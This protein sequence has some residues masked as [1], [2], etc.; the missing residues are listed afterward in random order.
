MKTPAKSPLGLSFS[1]R[2]RDTNG[3][4]NHFFTKLSEEQENLRCV[5]GAQKQ[6]SSEVRKK[7]V[8]YIQYLRQAH[9]SRN[10]ENEVNAHNVGAFFCSRIL[11]KKKRD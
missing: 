9:S 7:K 1:K 5:R 6:A 4:M 2:T 10:K 8:E 11:L 3:N